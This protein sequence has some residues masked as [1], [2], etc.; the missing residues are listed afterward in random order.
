[1]HFKRFAKTPRPRYPSLCIIDGWS[2]PVPGQEFRP[3]KYST[4]QGVLYR[5]LLGFVPTKAITEY[6]FRRP[7]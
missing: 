6:A 4:F 5:Q 2:E 7:K 3:P 1:M